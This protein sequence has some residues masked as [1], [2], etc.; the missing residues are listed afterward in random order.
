MPH[1][2]VFKA[3]KQYRH[4]IQEKQRPLGKEIALLLH[5]YLAAGKVYTMP[6][7][8]FAVQRIT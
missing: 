7:K 8:N 5:R 6:Y 3:S 2:A 1:V 4:P